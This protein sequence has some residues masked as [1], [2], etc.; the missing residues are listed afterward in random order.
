MNSYRSGRV[1]NLEHALLTV[2]LHLL[3]VGVLYR[4]V[5]LFDKDAL[6][7]LDRE[8]GLADTTA[9]QNH[10]F[11]LTHVDSIYKL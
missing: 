8:S 5:V 3:P 10:D 7:E 11:I 4:G 1:E 6:H 2:H 9:A